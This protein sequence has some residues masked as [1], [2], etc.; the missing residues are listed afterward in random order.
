LDLNYTITSGSVTMSTGSSWTVA[1]LGKAA[2]AS[3]LTV[4]GYGD[5]D[6]GTDI[7][8]AGSTFTFD[9]S[10]LSDADGL[11]IDAS[12]LT[13]AGTLKG[14]M[15][16]DTITGSNNG[17]TITG[18]NGVDDYIGGTG[19]DTLV[20]TETVA[21]ADNVT[22]TSATNGMDT[23][24]GFDFGGGASNDNI[25]LTIPNTGD[26][27]GGGTGV[28]QAVSTAINA[29]GATITALAANTAAAA[30]NDFVLVAVG[31]AS[32]VALTATNAAIKTAVAAKMADGAADIAANIT[33]AT[34]G[35]V[36]LFPNDANADG[37]VDSY[38][39]GAYLA[40]AT[41]AT[42]AAADL[43]IIGIFT[44]ADAANAAAADFT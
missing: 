4:S 5:V 22:M 30:G 7:V 35:F 33:A 26:I 41:F 9:A 11:H 24:T 23:V 38:F 14:S 16:A 12:N 27:A 10:G 1:T 31:D 28:D 6:E 39:L 8:L 2:T 34:E 37:T 32:A 44:D 18:G 15:Q 42:T 29:G 19:D 20:L 40:D 13:G 43:T 36:F 3:S 25:V 21:A 17:D